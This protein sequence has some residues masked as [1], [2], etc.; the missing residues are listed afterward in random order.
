ML[1]R[2]VELYLLA[3]GPL[4]SVFTDRELND[5]GENMVEK[6]IRMRW[7]LDEALEGWRGAHGEQMEEAQDEG[8]VDEIEYNASELRRLRPY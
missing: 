6:G 3:F 8:E 4:R 5:W 7:G 1:F 2:S